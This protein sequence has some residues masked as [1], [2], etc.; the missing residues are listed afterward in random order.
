[1]GDNPSQIRGKKRPVE[2]FRHKDALS[3]VAKLNESR[4]L[5]AGWVFTLYNYAGTSLSS[6][7]PN[8]HLRTAAVRT[9]R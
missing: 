7:Q 9:Y 2:R 4:L 1:M 5:P 6:S 3:F 8:P